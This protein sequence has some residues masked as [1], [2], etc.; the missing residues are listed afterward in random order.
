MTYGNIYVAQVAMGAS[1][2]Q[3][4]KAFVEAESYPGPSLIIAY[5][6]CI[7]HGINMLQGFDQQQLAVDSGAWIMYRYDPRRAEQGLNP[8]QLDSKAPKIPLKEYAY[9]ETRFKMLTQSKP[10]EAER[11]LV[12]AQ[13][14]VEERWRMYEQLASLDYSA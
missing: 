7:A 3:T 6:H 11:L 13:R 2:R 12:L 10:E 8:L 1:D 5:S 14:D 9:N 4:V